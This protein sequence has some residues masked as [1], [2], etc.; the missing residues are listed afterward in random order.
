MTTLK[1]YANNT[2]KMS[3]PDRYLPPPLEHFD[4]AAIQLDALYGSRFDSVA[5]SP[6]ARKELD[7]ALRLIQWYRQAVICRFE[8]TSDDTVTDLAD[9]LVG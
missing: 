3:D 8:E 2:E 6:L 7:R 1:I 9:K 5:L 4:R